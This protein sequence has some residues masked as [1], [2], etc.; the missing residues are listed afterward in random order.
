MIIIFNQEM[1][2]IMK[3]LQLRLY[4]YALTIPSSILHDYLHLFI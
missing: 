1:Q 4:I 2:M 3:K